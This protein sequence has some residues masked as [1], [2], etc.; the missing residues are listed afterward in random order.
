[1]LGQLITGFRQDLPGLLFAALIGLCLISAYRLLGAGWLIMKSEGELQLKAVGWAMSSLWLTAAGVLAISIATPWI[2]P[3]IFNKWFKFPNVLMLLPI[4]AVTLGLFGIMIRSIR[5]LPVRLEQ[6]NQYGAE[7]PFACTVG[8]FLLSFYGLAYSLFPWLVVDQLTIWKAAS[9][10]EALRV[11]FYG[12][13]VVF[14]VIVGYTVFAYRIF[15]GKTQA[16][17]Y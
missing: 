1:M 13:I 14:P 11:I 4:P 16:L 15:W 12:V 10:T 3:E 2:S 9:S 5:R 17:S 6:D 7:V 8:I